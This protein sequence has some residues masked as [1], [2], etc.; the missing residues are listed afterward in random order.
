MTALEQGS[1]RRVL[2]LAFGVAI[3]VG[4]VI[5]QGILRTPGIVA[6]GAP[7]PALIL[8]LW[9]FGAL[10][11][12]IDAMSIVELGSAVPKAGGPY[13][14]VERAFGRFGGFLTGWLDAGNLVITLAY[15]AVVVA[16]FLDRLDI[17]P[18]I[19][20]NFGSFAVSS[21]GALAALVVIVLGLINMLPTRVGGGLQNVSSAIKVAALLAFAVVCFAWRGEP[22]AAAAGGS[23]SPNALALSFVGLALAA[24]AIQQTYFGANTAV[25]FNEEVAAPEQNLARATFIGVG[26]VAAV[27]L[28]VNAALLNV[29]TVPEMAASN[30]PAADALNRALGSGGALAATL[31]ALF[32]VAAV[33]NVTL[34]QVSRTIFAMGRAGDLPRA[35]SIVL[36]TGA[37]VAA[38]AFVALFGALLASTGVYN[39][40]IMIAAPILA[41]INFLVA[42]SALR[43][44][45]K[46]PDLP[47][48]WK[49]PF[50]PAPAIFSILF[51]LGLM[52]FFIAS[53]LENTRW[54]VLFIIAAVPAYFSRR[55]WR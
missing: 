33:G 20:F 39:T 34:M 21:V 30:L 40:L 38:L 51:N 55:L 24:N 4:G 23:T 28:I 9:A 8:G 11:T 50:Y 1:L 29:L 54:S 27:Y 26:V 17:A 19:G 31:F 5:G 3:V 52:V 12:A 10:V 49:M 25:Y 35:L 36:R 13:V 44:R 43:V 16:E 15:I 41:F 45:M 47:R 18:A 6:A 14:F 22:G 7:D 37:P 42:V 48:P 2:G 53:D 32:S 46:E